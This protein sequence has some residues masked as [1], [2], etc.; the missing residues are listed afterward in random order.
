MTEDLRRVACLHYSAP[1]VVGGVE[2]VILAHAR[3]FVEAG[4]PTTV[5]AGNG[6]KEALPHAANFIRIRELDS[7]HPQVLALSHELEQGHVPPY[8][9]VMV[10]RLMKALAHSL[11]SVDY[12]IAHNIFTKHFNLPLTAALVRLLDQG[13]IKHC[14]AWCH[15]SSW[16]SP[17]SRARVHAG[18]PWDLLRRFHPQVR[19]V[20]VSRKRHR[21]LVNL[22]GCAPEQIKVIYNGVDAK[23]LLGLSDFGLTL[24][25]RLNLLESD[26]NLIMPERVT[27]AKNLELALR[28]TAALKAGG[29]RPRLVVT[30]PPDPHDSESMAYFQSLLSLRE[31][32]GVKRE[33]CFVFESGP[34]PR[35]PLTVEMPVVAELLRVSDGV[36]VPSHR[37]G[38]GMPVLEAGLMGIP[39]FCADTV[40]AAEEIGG[41][42][43]VSFSVAAGAA[44]VADLIM[45]RVRESPGLRLRRRIRQSFTWRS[46]FQREIMPL[47]DRGAA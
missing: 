14:I 4:Y 38:F 22:F 18:Y 26:L 41:Q 9:P 28:V 37:E 24:I 11:R 31:Q 13:L 20:T 27:R 43:V 40:P 47:L 2:S 10:A 25:D 15:D 19:Y 30:G 45:K 36:L 23:E 33:V 1:P 21:E 39:V 34:T 8:F 32:L 12:L 46:I 17:G 29:I 44:D 3:L 6:E 35:K 16:T 7:Q 5:L 42:D